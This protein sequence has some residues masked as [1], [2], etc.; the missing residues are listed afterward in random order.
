MI[1]MLSVYLVVL[2]CTL[3]SYYSYSLGFPVVSVFSAIASV[4]WACLFSYRRLRV[5]APKDLLSFFLF[6]YGY[7]LITS[8]AL[9][10]TNDSQI[11]SAFLI[12]LTVIAIAT[13]VSPVHINHILIFVVVA[14]VFFFFLQLL[15]YVFFDISFDFL[16]FFDGESQRVFG[17]SFNL[18]FLGKFIRPAGLFNEPGTYTT[19]LAPLV[20]CIPVACGL[21]NRCA[22]YTFYLALFS[23]VL[24]LS[25]QG[26]LSACLINI[27]LILSAQKLY[28]SRTLVGILS[29]SGCFLIYALPYL[30]YR[31]LGN[32]YSVAADTGLAIRQDMFSTLFAHFQSEYTF[33]PWLGPGVISADGVPNDLSLFLY[34]FFTLGIIPSIVLLFIPAR[35]LLRSLTSSYASSPNG[36]IERHFYIAFLL[37]VCSTKFN[38]TSIA[39]SVILTL[40]SAA[41]ARSKYQSQQV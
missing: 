7:S 40:A 37:I 32:E 13:I 4:A 41:F 33:W 26:I 30:E 34:F 22:K 27:A 17:G 6:I 15:S 5:S 21:T 19:F 24:S 12:P 8:L 39:G 10:Q 23:L 35:Y 14:H 2:G 9:K 29:F 18:P 36:Q 1:K 3:Q 31:F 28:N 25:V 16:A 20:T 11:L 38:T